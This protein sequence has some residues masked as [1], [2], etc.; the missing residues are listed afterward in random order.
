MKILNDVYFENR[1]LFFGGTLFKSWE[2]YVEYTKKE[3]EKN[4]NIIRIVDEVYSSQKGIFKR[5]YVREKLDNYEP[6]PD[7]YPYEDYKEH[8]FVLDSRRVGLADDGLPF[9]REYEV[10]ALDE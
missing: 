7:G 5:F 1:K 4:G 8:S 6:F 2:H 3:I 10:V 9:E